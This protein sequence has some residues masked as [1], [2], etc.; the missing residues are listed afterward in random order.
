MPAAMRYFTPAEANALL[1][2][3]TP[4][5]AEAKQH[6]ARVRDLSERAAGRAASETELEAH[7]RA[8]A[9]ILKAIEGDGVSVKGLDPALLDFPAMYRGREVLLCWREGEESVRNWHPVS[10]GFAGRQPLDPTDT[11]AWEWRN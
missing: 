2:R 10:T 6:L 7:R 5:V 8:L 9:D 4:L 3:L 1:P 11:R